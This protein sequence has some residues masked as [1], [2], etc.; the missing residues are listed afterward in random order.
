MPSITVIFVCA[1]CGAGYQATQKPLTD[2]TNGNFQCE[3]C[4][5]EIYAWTGA[6]TY[7]DW[8]A[9]ET[10]PKPNRAT[11]PKERSSK[12]GTGKRTSPQVAGPTRI[13]PSHLLDLKCNTE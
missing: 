12:G 11:P 10:T 3:V 9:A 1:K 13:H 5:T 4:H 7:I 2:E 6:Y 8:R